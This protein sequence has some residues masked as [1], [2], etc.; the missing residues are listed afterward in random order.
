MYKFETEVEIK[1]IA[2]QNVTLLW[3][4]VKWIFISCS[5]G[6]NV[7]FLHNDVDVKSVAKPLSTFVNRKRCTNLST[8][9]ARALKMNGNSYDTISF[10]WWKSFLVTTLTVSRVQFSFVNKITNES[11]IRFDLSIVFDTCDWVVLEKCGFNYEKITK[12]IFQCAIEQE[13]SL[14]LEFY[15]N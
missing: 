1:I 2:N 13:V 5:G 10:W 6:W 9:K 11:C 14:S 8:I 15:I 3:C 12:R 4:E 7:N